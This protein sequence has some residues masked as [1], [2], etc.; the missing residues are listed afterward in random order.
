MRILRLFTGL[1]LTGHVLIKRLESTVKHAEKYRSKSIPLVERTDRIPE[2]KECNTE[3]EKVSKYTT[4]ESRSMLSF[5]LFFRPHRSPF[6]D[7]SFIRPD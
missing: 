7:G 2:K 5:V 1:S 4:E 3:G 6:L